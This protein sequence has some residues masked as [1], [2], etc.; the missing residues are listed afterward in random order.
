VPTITNCLG[1]QALTLGSNCG[2]QLPDYRSFVTATD[3]C[4]ANLIFV[5]T[6]SPGTEIFGPTDIMITVTDGSNNVSSCQFE[7]TLSDITPPAISTC[8]ENQLIDLGENCNY[9][10][11]NFI[12]INEIAATDNCDNNVFLIQNPAAGSILSSAQTVTI[13]AIDD[14]GNSS[15][16]SFELTPQDNTAPIIF[17]SDDLFELNLNINCQAILPDYRGTVSVSDNCSGAG[18]MQIIQ[19]PPSGTVVTEYTEVTFTVIDLAGNISL[20]CSIHVSVRDVTPPSISCQDDLTFITEE[21]LTTVS[22][23]LELPIVTDNCTDSPTVWNTTN[24]SNE[25]NFVFPIGENTVTWMTTDMAGNESQCSVTVTV[26]SGDLPIIECEPIIELYSTLDECGVTVDL[27]APAASDYDGIVEL[28]NDYTNQLEDVH[29]SIGS[30]SIIWTAEDGLGNLGYCTTSV[31]VYDTIS[32]LVDCSS[33][34]S[35]FTL[36]GESFGEVEIEVPSVN[37]ACVYGLNNELNPNGLPPTTYFIGLHSLVWTATD[38][39]GNIGQCTTVI[40]IED[41]TPPELVCADPVSYPTDQ[42]ECSTWI[43]VPAPLLLIDEANVIITNSF[44]NTNNASGNYEIGQHSIV[45]TATDVNNNSTTCTQ[46]ITVYDGQAPVV[47]C[48]QAIT[49][50]TVENSCEAE[51]TLQTPLATD[52]C[53]NE[54]IIINTSN[55][56]S[57]YY[58]SLTPGEHDFSW[59]AFDDNSNSGYCHVTVTVVD[60]TGFHFECPENDSILLYPK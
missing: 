34:I 23:E 12:S 41:N 13:T 47:L 16:C 4:S 38:L 32:P 53:D 5:Q 48:D 49:V 52:N 7:V 9:S 10:V 59:I 17:C 43:N 39:S 46:I 37:E 42:D 28:S 1:D 15:E 35:G 22:V 57:V 58:A 56:A 44:N 18:Q 14:S 26:I 6:P 54:I 33:I 2:A 51:V 45:W 27:L 21:E 31:M 8:P 3:V 60:T 55:D 24:D 30:H 25:E 20:P 50:Y 40:S 11:P 29:F 19:S 36:S